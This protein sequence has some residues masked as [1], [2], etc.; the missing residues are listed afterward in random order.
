MQMLSMN[1]YNYPK[2][3]KFL[4]FLLIYDYNN[5]Y[6]KILIFFLD[7]LLLIISMNKFNFFQIHNKLIISI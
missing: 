1:L 7:L 2:V 3:A 5:F 6:F 4:T